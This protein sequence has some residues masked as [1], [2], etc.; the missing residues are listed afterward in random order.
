MS[1]P[2]LT[3]RLVAEFAGT[4]L[5]LATVVGSGIMGETRPSPFMP[6]VGSS[7]LRYERVSETL[8]GPLRPDQVC[9]MLMGM[10]HHYVHAVSELPTGIP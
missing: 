6:S 4:A 7:H 2:S 1:Q 10:Q 5:L 8:P 3:P 9:V